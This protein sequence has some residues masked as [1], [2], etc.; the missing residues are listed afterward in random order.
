MV[1]KYEEA[2][3]SATETLACSHEEHQDW[4]Q[5]WRGPCRDGTVIV[6]DV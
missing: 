5:S 6:R 1:K 2:A 4:G 3:A